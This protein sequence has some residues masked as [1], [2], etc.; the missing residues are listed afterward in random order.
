MALYIPH[1]IFHLARL[2]YVRPE[3]FGPYY[4][5][6]DACMNVHPMH[7]YATYG[8]LFRTGYFFRKNKI[9]RKLSSVM[10]ADSPI[11]MNMLVHSNKRIFNAPYFA[12]Y[13][14]TLPTYRCL[15]QTC[16]I[17][18]PINRPVQQHSTGGPFTSGLFKLSEEV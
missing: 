15:V 14:L 10:F 7:S 1:S 12:L 9:F 5:F 3:T 13:F 16:F 18:F 11:I 4:V 2:L 17:G 6:I 8:M